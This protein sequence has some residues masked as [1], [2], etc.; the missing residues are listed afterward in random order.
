MV[1]LGLS[2]GLRQ[3]GH[4]HQKDPEA[5]HVDRVGVR[6]EESAQEHGEAG[7]QDS[8]DDKDVESGHGCLTVSSGRRP[9]P[10][11]VS[12]SDHT[13]ENRIME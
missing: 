12:N 10:P 5:G 11:F 13:I 9:G 7:S 6:V 4:A 8:A 1:A 3:V 2:P